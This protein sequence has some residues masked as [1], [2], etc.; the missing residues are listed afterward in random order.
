MQRRKSHR[1]VIAAQVRWRAA[2]A[3]AQAERDAGIP[4]REPYTDTREPIQLDL[5]SA[6]GQKL[7][8]EPRLGYVSWR[9]RDVDTGLVLHCAALKELLH[10][11]AEDLPRMASPNTE[12]KHR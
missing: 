5:T 1:H 6:G 4:D 12:H 2:E 11:I 9:A 7:L 3:R 10:R 8:L